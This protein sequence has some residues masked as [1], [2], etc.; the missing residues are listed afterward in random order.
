MSIDEAIHATTTPSG[1]E[2]SS[3]SLCG[4]EPELVSLR[5]ASDQVAS[6]QRAFVD[7]IVTA[8]AAGCPWSSIGSAMDVSTQTAREVYEHC[9][10]GLAAR[11]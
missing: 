8:R 5:G 9:R 6:A 10:N 11:R 4:G 7:A 1:R 2:S 3:P